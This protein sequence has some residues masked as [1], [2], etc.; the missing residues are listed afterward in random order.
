MNVKKS[1]LFAFFL[2][3]SVI[4]S[5]CGEN[6]NKN[7]YKVPSK[8][9]NYYI[10]LQKQKEGKI[11]EAKRLFSV[12]AKKSSSYIA[13]RSAEKLTEIGNIQERLQA[14]EN[15]VKKYNDEDALLIAA[16]QFFAA[17]EYTRVL[18]LTNNVNYET[19]LNALIYLRLSSM[20][21]NN[22]SRL[23]S[24]T[25]EWFLSRPFS[26]EH[27][28]F[29]CDIA[30]SADFL[31]TE[32][33]NEDNEENAEFIKFID[34]RAEV[35]KRNYK[36]AYEKFQ[37]LKEN[38][39]LKPQS[40][41]DVGKICVYGSSDFLQN[42]KFF[43][44]LTKKVEGTN[45][46][47]YSNFYAGRLYEK[48]D[49]TTY[50][51]NRYISA[52]N[53]AKTDELYD[54]A[55]W[56]LLS[57]NLKKSTSQGIQM[58]KKYCSTW[59]NPAYFDDIFDMLSPLMLSEGRWNE[60]YEIYKAIDGYATDGMTAKFAYIYGRLVQEKIALPIVDDTHKSEDVAAFT[61][62]LISGSD[63]YY[64]ILAV[65]KLGLGGE[66]AEEILCS[67][68]INLKKED[69]ADA[70]TENNS[71]LQ[72]NSQNYETQ[73]TS[74]TPVDF[75]AENL[76]LGYV[77]F[78]FPEK[79][80]PEWLFLNRKNCNISYETGIKIAKFLE[81]C[82]KNKN[83][84]YPQ[85]LR[86]A[87]KV[88]NSTEKQVP[89]EDLKLL[90]PQDYSEILSEKCAKY[91]VPEEIM[92]ALV[93]SESFF[94]SQIESSAGAIG[95]TQ[96]MTFT[97]SDIAH[98]LK[99]KEYNLKNPDDNLEFG[100]WYLNNL[101]G[102]LENRWLSAFFAYNAG[103]TRVRRWEKSSKIAF[104]N[105]KNLPDDL[106]LEIIPYQETREYGRKLVGAATMYSWLYY[107][108]EVSEEVLEIIK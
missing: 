32:A 17:E 101:A 50:A 45:A 103:I 92:Y 21:K 79:I 63:I 16:E 8:D 60:F 22:N 64:K 53:C 72:I 105:I 18:V 9:K 36:I 104:N 15:L 107:G 61:R 33:K 13:R 39:P 28:K 68:K 74:E 82:G 106:F 96:L 97:G 30:K 81:T 14:C 83:E 89:K 20:L 71:E 70:T 102:R 43:D 47:F 58:I 100:T 55:L 52:M 51:N 7:L 1:Y 56:Y 37:N 4:F 38:L 23:V 10:A 91:N 73:D 49:Y 59:H 66:R 87:S 29:Y 35:Y 5:S 42:A 2:G 78:G 77:S 3:F 19:S 95:L 85:A 98:R 44:E 108:K 90:F 40:I 27:Y 88:I 34:L 54:N 12:S 11:S 84:Y 65:S 25:F 46:E 6:A 31:K 57:L 67:P 41:S 80:Y 93:R 24:D 26:S 94:D 48:I 86:I 99:Y 76:L 75:A 62:A 69:N